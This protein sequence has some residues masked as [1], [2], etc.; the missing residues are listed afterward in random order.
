MENIQL[1]T[2]V[3]NNVYIRKFEE[4]SITVLKK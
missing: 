1:E 4:N 2:V 3:K